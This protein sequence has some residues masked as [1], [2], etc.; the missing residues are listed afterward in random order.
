M[1]AGP[2]SKP[3]TIQ[4][5]NEK[6]ISTWV[7]NGSLKGLSSSKELAAAVLAKRRPKSPVDCFVFTPALELVACEEA[8]D[9][10]GRRDPSA[11]YF[12]FLSEALSKANP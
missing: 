8:N 6:F 4:F 5:L 9:L 3:E 11:V 10:L 1:R 12:R 2:L 7:L